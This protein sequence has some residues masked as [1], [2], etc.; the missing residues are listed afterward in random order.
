MEPLPDFLEYL[1]IA[2]RWSKG[3]DDLIEGKGPPVR[4]WMNAEMVLI[5]AESEAQRRT[6]KRN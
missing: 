5:A 3:P 4:W 2:R 1:Y 6:R